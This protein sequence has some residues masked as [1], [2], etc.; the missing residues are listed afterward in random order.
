[1][2]GS[3]LHTLVVYWPLAAVFVVCSGGAEHLRRQNLSSQ[4]FVFMVGLWC[5]G[6]TN[7]RHVSISVLPLMSR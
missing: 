6:M 5:F 1:M 2:K 7:G 4:P 3:H